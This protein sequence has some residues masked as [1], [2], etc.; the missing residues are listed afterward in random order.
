M[1]PDTMQDRWLLVPG[2][3]RRRAE[4]AAQAR[5]YGLFFGLGQHGG[6]GGPMGGP[7]LSIRGGGSALRGP[8]GAVTT[9]WGGAAAPWEGRRRR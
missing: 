7:A 4:L 1:R 9:N 6:T 3:A 8:G 2:W 5:S